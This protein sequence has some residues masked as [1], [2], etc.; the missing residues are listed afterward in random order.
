MEL[1]NKGKK[2]MHDKFESDMWVSEL[3]DLVKEQSKAW[4]R[5]FFVVLALWAATIAGFMWYLNQYDFVSY[6][7]DGNGNNYMNSDVGGDVHNGAEVPGTEEKE[8]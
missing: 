4:R 5:A 6:E 8:P 1:E 3:I 2:E 7:Q